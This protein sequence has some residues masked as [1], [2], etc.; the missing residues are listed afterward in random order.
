[1]LDDDLNVKI[2]TRQA[3]LIKKDTKT[4]S[5][6]SVLNDIVRKALK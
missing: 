6:S 3:H 5:F 1:M 2:R 4:H